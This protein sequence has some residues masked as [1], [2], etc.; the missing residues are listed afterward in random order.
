MRWHI[1]TCEN[2]PS[3]L[4]FLGMARFKKSQS[5]NDRVASCNRSVLA[6]K[7]QPKLNLG[8]VEE[9]SILPKPN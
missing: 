2:Q 3:S 8:Q 7:P 6:E 9:N 5:F 4:L 1:S